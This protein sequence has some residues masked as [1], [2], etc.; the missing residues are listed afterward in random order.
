MEIKSIKQVLEDLGRKSAVARID[1]LPGNGSISINGKVF[2]LY[3]QNNP[4][5]LKT[6]LAPLVL[7]NIEKNYNIIIKAHG[8]GLNGQAEAI[9]L[10]ISKAFYNLV[11]VES[12]K[13]L[14]AENFLTRNSLCKE[15]R[16][17]GLKKARKAPQFSKR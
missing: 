11:D 3:M 5:L 16:K 6:I 1:I 15:R 8:G 14:K 7:L 13:K 4:K 17:Y 10:G 9:K 2:N 12:Q